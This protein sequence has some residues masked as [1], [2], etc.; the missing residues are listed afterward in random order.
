MFVATKQRDVDEKKVRHTSQLKV[1]GF[2][3]L[4]HRLNK[5]IMDKILNPQDPLKVH[6]DLVTITAMFERDGDQYITV[7]Y[8]D[9]KTKDICLS[10]Y[11]VLCNKDGSHVFDYWVV[12]V[13]PIP[14]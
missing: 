11:G 5:G 14:D 3:Y 4:C 10:D 8:I 1:W 7:K 13:V 9:G 2:Y 6:R 12:S